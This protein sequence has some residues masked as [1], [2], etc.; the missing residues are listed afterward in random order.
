MI[1]Q[2]N[3]PLPV[4]TPKGKGIAHL[5][6]DPGIESDLLWVVFQ[7]D[8][9]ECWTWRNQDIKAQKNITMGRTYVKES[10][11]NESGK[12]IE[13]AREEGRKSRTCPQDGNE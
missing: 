1:L 4:L 8:S 10:D 7:D 11:T 9:G 6:I 5:I 12:G 2:L 3:P 13:A